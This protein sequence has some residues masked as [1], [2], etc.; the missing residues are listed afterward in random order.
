MASFANLDIRT[1]SHKLAV[2]LHPDEMGPLIGPVG[3]MAVQ[4]GKDIVDT[5]YLLVR[6]VYVVDI[7]KGAICAPMCCIPMIPILPPI[8]GL[9]LS[10]F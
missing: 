6:L 10:I 5:V 2:Y 8:N 3:L 1:I 9:K 4:T 7:S